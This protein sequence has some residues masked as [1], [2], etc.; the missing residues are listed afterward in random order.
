M[1]AVFEIRDASMNDDVLGILFYFDR[2]KR[3]FIELLS[4]YDEWDA[5][6][7]L[8]GFVERKEYSIDSEWSMKWVRQRIVPPERQN[9]GA[10]LKNAGLDHY[11]E[12]KLLLLSEGRGAQDDL[13][14]KRISE[15]GIPD[16]IRTRLKKKVRDVIPLS[17][18]R[19]LVFFKDGKAG[20]LDI[21]TKCGENRIFGNVLSSAGSFDQVKVSPGGNGIEWDEDR[22]ISAETLYKEVTQTDDDYDAYLRFTSLRLAETANV[23]DV[24]ECTRQYV[25]RMVRENKIAPVY[26]GG[27]TRMF[28]KADIEA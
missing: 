22:F 9:I 20:R 27:Q 24:M 11:D 12:Y 25:S 4:Q 26:T 13:Y 7:L 1:S 28:L 18:N 19:V 10:I 6:F 3:F 5:P 14:I 16:E 17:D 21:N 8:V 15:D 2:S 23:C